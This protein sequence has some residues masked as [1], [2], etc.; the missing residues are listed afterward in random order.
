MNPARVFRQRPFFTYDMSAPS[1]LASLWRTIFPRIQPYYAVK[2]NPDVELI[3]ALAGENVNFDCASMGEIELVMNRGVPASRIIFAHTMKFPEHLARAAGLGVDLTTFDGHHELAKIARFHPA[4]RALLRI[5]SDDPDA[6][7][8]LGNKFG[9]EPHEIKGLLEKARDL[10]VN[11]KGVAF[12]VGSG[13]KNAEAYYRAIRLAAETFGV[14]Q[15]LGFA[16]DTLDIGGGFCVNAGA[17]GLEGDVDVRIN[18]ALN[19]FFPQDLVKVVAEPGRFFSE[20][21]GSYAVRV[22]GKR[23]RSGAIEYFLNDGVYGAFGNVVYEKYVPKN[24]TV[25]RAADDATGEMFD[26]VLYGPTCDS[27]DTLGN[28]MLP[29]LDVDDWLVFERFGAYTAA[30]STKF[31]GYGHHDVYYD[32][33]SVPENVPEGERSRGTTRSPQ[34]PRRT[35][36]GVPHRHLP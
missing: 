31:N 10:G 1:R 5:R 30:T 16:P 3:D 6:R 20:S 2:S 26:S 4:S 18:A 19:E 34:S 36:A 23:E 17:T 32:D 33:F 35:P 24:V 7:C 27:V 28:V 9:A 13:S 8:L 15:T 14:A 29:K 12:H 21:F 22:V 25:H 11:F